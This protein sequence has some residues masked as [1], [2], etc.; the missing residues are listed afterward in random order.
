[1]NNTYIPKSRS[2]G[3]KAENKET[4]SQ[5]TIFIPANTYTHVTGENCS[6][7]DL[8]LGYHRR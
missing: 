2:K 3:K 4:Q 6:A 5:I 8:V 1:M 7:C